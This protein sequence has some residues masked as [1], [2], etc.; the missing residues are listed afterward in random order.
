MEPDRPVLT[1]R[2]WAP[3][4]VAVLHRPDL[5]PVAL[6]VA[7]R[8]A[9]ARWWRRWPPRPRPDPGY[10][11]FRMQTAYGD[12]DRAPDPDD[13]VAWLEWCRRLRRPGR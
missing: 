1:L 4:V 7:L 6:L 12:P 9:P 5:W 11:A 8:L 13:L 10:L 2:G 3:A